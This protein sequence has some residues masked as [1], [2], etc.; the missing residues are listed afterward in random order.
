MVTTVLN[1]YATDTFKEE[2]CLYILLLYFGKL[3]KTV[4]SVDHGEENWSTIDVE[5]ITCSAFLKRTITLW[6][7]ATVQLKQKSLG[8]KEYRIM[9]REHVE[10]VCK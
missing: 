4:L 3:L 5:N 10:I 8:L 6:E 7:N 2:I 9:Y 1:I